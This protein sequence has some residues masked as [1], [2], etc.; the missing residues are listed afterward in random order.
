[1]YFVVKVVTTCGHY[2]CRICI[3]TV[4][5]NSAKNTDRVLNPGQLYSTQI[6]KNISRTSFRL[7]KQSFPSSFTYRGLYRGLR[8]NNPREEKP[9]QECRCFLQSVPDANLFEQ[10][11]NDLQNASFECPECREVISCSKNLSVMHHP[12]QRLVRNLLLSTP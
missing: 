2:F 5:L 12:S 11:L 3:E 7:C 10:R 6:W 8:K 9:C 1:M 4:A